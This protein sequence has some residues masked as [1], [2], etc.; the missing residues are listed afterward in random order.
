VGAG[1]GV[2]TNFSEDPAF[3]VAAL[4]LQ[5]A[6][7]ST[8]G[9][10]GGNT[11]I[12]RTTNG[13]QQWQTVN[14]ANITDFINDI[15]FF[16]ANEGI[17]LGDPKGGRWGVARTTNG[18]E[19]WQIQTGL[20][21]PQ[22]QETGLVGSRFWLDEAGWFGTTKGRVFY[23]TDKGATWKVSTIDPAPANSRWNYLIDDNGRVLATEDNGSSWEVMLTREL[24]QTRMAALSWRGS[25]VRIWNVGPRGLGYLNLPYEEAPIPK[26]LLFNSEIPGKRR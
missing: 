5:R 20:P 3:A 25:T 19:T 23:T 14:V 1:L 11:T 16:N 22:P 7:I 2:F 18:G 8:N 13:G 26:V 12:W 9:P 15:H 24:T 17:F 10:N 6:W 4:G 21:A